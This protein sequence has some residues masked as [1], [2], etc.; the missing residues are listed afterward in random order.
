LHD[1][2]EKKNVK[3]IR[4]KNGNGAKHSSIR[5]GKMSMKCNDL[6]QQSERPH[7]ASKASTATTATETVTFQIQQP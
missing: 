5:Q 6:Q 1:G 4:K 7:A 2:G 3:P